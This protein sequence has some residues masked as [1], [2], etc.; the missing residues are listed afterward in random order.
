MNDKTEDLLQDNRE[1]LETVAN[2]DCSASWIADRLL[3]SLEGDTSS[4]TSEP[5]ETNIDRDISPQN[6][7]EEQSK[8][9]PERKD[10]VFA[11]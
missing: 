10:S 9:P 5:K 8:D 3:D 7:P 6:P 1:T 4:S 11:Y 2:A